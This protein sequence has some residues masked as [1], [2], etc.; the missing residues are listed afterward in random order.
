MNAELVIFTAVFA[1]LGVG[2]MLRPRGREVRVPR[3]VRQAPVVSFP[4]PQLLFSPT[5]APVA[6][7]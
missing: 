3:L 7:C 4:R 2:L 1:L 6:R 5:L